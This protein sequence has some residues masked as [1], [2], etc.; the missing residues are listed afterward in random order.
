M[1]PEPWFIDA[2]TRGIQQTMLLGLQG[3][4]AGELMEGTVK[5]WCI[6]LWRRKTWAEHLD[7]KRIAEGFAEMMGEVDRWPA[8]SDFLRYLPNRPEIPVLTRQISEEERAANLER[9]SELIESIGI[10]KNRS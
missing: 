6:A 4:P 1:K 9:L 8:P 7:R 3:Q 5:A 2:I 10:K